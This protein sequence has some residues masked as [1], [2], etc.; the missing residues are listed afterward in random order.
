MWLAMDALSTRLG[1]AI[2]THLDRTGTSPARLGADALGDPSF[3][4]RLKRGRVPRLG[5]ADRVLAFIGGEPFGPAFRAEVEAFIEVTRTKPY[6][7][8]LDAAGDPSFVARLRKGASPRLDTA[9]KVIRWMVAHCCAE[10]RD[11][12]R[13]ALGQGPETGISESN[14][15]TKKEGL[16]S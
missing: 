10:E 1:H 16:P 4:L 3:V 15:I 8:G 12:I 5:T 13:A 14:P 2:Q 6:V 11:A 7:L 9:A